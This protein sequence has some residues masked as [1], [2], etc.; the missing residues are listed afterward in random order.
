MVFATDKKKKRIPPIALPHLQ[1]S[2]V[3]HEDVFTRAEVAAI[4]KNAI[5][6]PQVSRISEVLA[7]IEPFR[8]IT[9]EG[10]WGIYVFLC[11]RQRRISKEGTQWAWREH[12]P[13]DYEKLGE[14]EFLRTY[15]YSIG[16][17]REDCDRMIDE[18]LAK[19]NTKKFA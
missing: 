13:E 19:K 16:G 15:V 9:R 6:A 8:P 4:F 3:F 11:W 12:F 14:T 18:F 5:D 10:V 7:V 1:H 17:S 2:T